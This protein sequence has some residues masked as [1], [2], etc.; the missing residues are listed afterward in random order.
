MQDKANDFLRR[1]HAGSGNSGAVSITQAQE[2]VRLAKQ[3]FYDNLVYELWK[4]RE[5]RSLSI[6]SSYAA[7]TNLMKELEKLKP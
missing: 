7:M 2:A 3:D 4:F 5:E 1:C 6:K